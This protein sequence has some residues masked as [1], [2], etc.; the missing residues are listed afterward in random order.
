[1]KRLLL[2]VSV[3]AG[4]GMAAAPAMSA[5][6]PTSLG[7]DQLNWPVKDGLYEFRSMGGEFAAGE[8]LNFVAS[9][10]SGD[11]DT[12]SAVYL[13][14]DGVETARASFPGTLTYTVPTSGYY[15]F[16]WRTDTGRATWEVSCTAAPDAD[17]DGASDG[18]DNC[19]A[20]YNPDQ[21]D[22]DRDG[23]GDVCDA[24]D[25][26]PDCSDVV[27][28]PK[29]LKADG[30]LHEVALT[31]ASDADGDA[32]IYSITAVSQDEPTSGGFRNDLNTPDAIGVSGNTVSLRGERNPSLNGRVYRIHYTVTAGDGLQCT[33]FATVGVP[34]RK[35]VVPV[36]DGAQASWNSYT[37]ALVQ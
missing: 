22:V 37:G 33:G 21:A 32:L 24:T 6:A 9:H 5:Q 18:S 3:A 1:M 31:G 20:A 36:D 23:V 16:F 11:T 2:T 10:P 8:E 29:V 25:G 35:N 14:L 26:R 15:D 12:P 30:K 17:G 34:T 7:C 19:P 27:A 28:T 4:L 13:D